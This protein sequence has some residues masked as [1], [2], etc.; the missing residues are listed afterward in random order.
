M[1]KKTKSAPQIPSVGRIILAVIS[2]REGAFAELVTRPAIIVRTWPGEKINEVTGAVNAQVFM[3]GDGETSNDGT[4][5]CLWRS[6]LQYDE[7]GKGAH[8]WHWPPRV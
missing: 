5:N 3:D 6:S 4:P 2:I 7:T 1:A 8:T